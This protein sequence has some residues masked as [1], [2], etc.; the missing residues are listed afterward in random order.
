MKIEAGLKNTSK[1][2]T[3]EDKKFVLSLLQVEGVGRKTAKR[4]IFFLIK[5]E[6]IFSSFWVNKK[7]IWQKCYLSE[8]SI[9]STKSVYREQ[10]NCSI[11]D[12]LIKQNIRVIAFWEN[13]YPILLKH[14]DDFPLILFL[15]GNI[16]CLQN[17]SIAVVGTRRMTEYG[18]MATKKIVE[19]L[20]LEGFAIV[21]GF[22]YGIDLCAHLETINNNGL[23]VAVLGFGFD[24]MYPRGNRKYFDQ[25]INHSGC[26]ITEYLPEV[27]PNVGNFPNRNRIVAGLCKGVIVVEAGIKSGSH[28]TA[29]CALNEGREVFAVPGPINNPFSEGTKWLINQG[30]IMI[31]SGYDVVSQLRENA[32][33]N[34]QI[35]NQ[36]TSVNEVSKININ[37]Q[38]VSQ[39]ERYYVNNEVVLSQI[40]KFIIAE[41]QAG[42]KSFDYFTEKINSKTSKIIQEVTLLEINDIVTVEGNTLSLKL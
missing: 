16:S 38:K 42:A 35:S 19:E 15:K 24:H 7:N 37:N 39:I 5:H 1:N 6:M 10:K 8:K 34:R 20:V 32:R 21:S 30:A 26:F 22:M 13:E 33:G 40:Q 9:K 41:L 3:L 27:G 2:F 25:I 4:I 31:T 14:C 18:I 12:R 11:Y 29:E 17:E 36:G 23:T 28:I